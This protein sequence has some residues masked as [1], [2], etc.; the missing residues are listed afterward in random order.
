MSKEEKIWKHEKILW[1]L[2]KY[3]CEVP[4]SLIDVYLKELKQIHETYIQPIKDNG[5]SSN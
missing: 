2:Q 5:R 3:A 4:D 1:E